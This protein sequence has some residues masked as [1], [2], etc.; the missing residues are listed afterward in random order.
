MAELATLARPYAEALFQAAQGSNLAAWSGWLQQLAH[1]ASLPEVHA[2]VTN[3]K[4]ERAQ[5]YEL[6]LSGVTLPAAAEQA[7]QLNNLVQILTDM[8]RLHVLNEI[9]TQFDA[10]KNAS[11]G[12][13]D[14]LITSAF[15]L[16]GEALSTLLVAL[17]RKFGCK[18]KPH[19]TIDPALIGGI[20]VTVGDKVHDTS[21]RTRLAQMRS[22]LTA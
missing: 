18:L 22:A 20:C 8:H 2:V 16:K 19:V 3:P 7:G 15:E 5:I 11:E 6:L 9:A 17:E 1:I 10:L 14:A 13:A 4:I 12:A 21:V